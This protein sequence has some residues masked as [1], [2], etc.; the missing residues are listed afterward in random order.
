MAGYVYVAHNPK[1]YLNMYK[2]GFTSRTVTARLRELSHQSPHDLQEYA[3]RVYADP[4]RAERLV[5]KELAQFRVE[6]KE[7]FNIPRRSQHLIKEALD[8]V[9]KRLQEEEY[10]NVTDTDDESTVVDEEEECSEYTPSESDRDEAE[11]LTDMEDDN[12]SQ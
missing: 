9:Q 5:H 6:G 11:D 10:C 4:S 7:W 3:S 2:I 1:V 12:A 8:I